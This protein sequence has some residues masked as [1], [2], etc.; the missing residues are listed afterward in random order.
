MPASERRASG[1]QAEVAPRAN[2]RAR[3]SNSPAASSTVDTIATVDGPL[4]VDSV[5]GGVV[6]PS[7]AFAARVGLSFKGRAVGPVALRV[8]PPPAPCAE[9]ASVSAL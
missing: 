2:R 6:V 9:L 7:P 5:A 1:R 3:R 8:V 4:L